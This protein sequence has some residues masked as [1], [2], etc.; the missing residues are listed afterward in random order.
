V[1][2]ASG[3]TAVA[4]VAVLGA[5]LALSGLV[6]GPSHDTVP[7]G[8]AAPTVGEEWAFFT[9]T[10]TF[11][12]KPVVGPVSMTYEN[13]IRVDQGRGY[14]GQTMVSDDPRMTGERT[15]INNAWS[16]SGNGIWSSLVTIDTTEGAWTCSTTGV[17]VGKSLGGESG[18]CDGHEAYEGLRAYIAFDLHDSGPYTTEDVYGYI[19]S[20]DGPPAVE[21]PI[22]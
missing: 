6:S 16:A 11:D 22:E 8:A 17:W 20:G 14:S 13:G 21:A 18:W 9:G 12:G 2:I 19:T 5:S 10:L 3:A 7:P 1:F 4:T 15:E